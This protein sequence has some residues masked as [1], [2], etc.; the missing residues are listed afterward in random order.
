MIR[1]ATVGTSFIC[2]SFLSGAGL[3]KRFLLSAVYSRNAETGK[4]FG[5]KFGCDT[6]FCDLEEMAKSPSVD[7]V[8]IASPNVFHYDQSKL[9]LQNKKHVICEKPITSNLSQYKELKA[10]ADKNGVIYMEA[11]IPL[12]TDHYEKVKTAFKKIGNPVSA[13]FDFSQRSSRLDSFLKGEQVNIFDMS[14]HAGTLM[15]LGVYCV[16]AACDFF[17]QPKKIIANANFFEN[18]ADK[19]GSALFTYDDFSVFLSYC[20]NAQGN[21]GS[22]IIGENGVLKIKFISQY[23]GVSLVIDGQEE[24]VAQFPSKPELMSGEARKFADYIE[25]FEEFNSDYTEKSNLCLLVHKCMD[26]IKSNA[27]LSYSV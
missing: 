14:L 24:L 8:Y 26:E 19:S 1:L 7:A 12:H 11:I 9:F 21:L 22:E 10:L 3:T 5:E 23:A 6:V 18:G 27:E 15:D 13:R 20:K 2:E 25:H 17:G 16:Y 4:A